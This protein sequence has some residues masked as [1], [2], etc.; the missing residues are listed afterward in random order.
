MVLK[1]DNNWED[2]FYI[3]EYTYSYMGNSYTA[4]RARFKHNNRCLS[5]LGSEW[6][7]QAESKAY[8]WVNDPAN[9]KEI[10]EIL[11]ELV[12]KGDF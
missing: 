1:L 6:K 4:F 5:V 2:I 10:L 9:D 3:E 7:V 12:L 8:N 11:T